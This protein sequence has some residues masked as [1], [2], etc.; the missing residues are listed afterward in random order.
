MATK[1]L[2]FSAILDVAALKHECE[3]VFQGDGQRVAD[4]RS[5]LLPIFKKASAQGRERARWS[6]Q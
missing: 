2:D 1:D 5:D 6:L 3:L 4:V